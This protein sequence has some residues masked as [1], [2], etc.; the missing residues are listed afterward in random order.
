MFHIKKRNFDSGEQQSTT[1]SPV[2][3][4]SNKTSLLVV[5]IVGRRRTWTTLTA[6]TLALW[7]WLSARR[8]A[9][10]TPTVL[11]T[12]WPAARRRPRTTARIWARTTRQTTMSQNAFRQVHQ[13]QLLWLYNEENTQV[14]FSLK[15]KTI[16]QSHTSYDL[17]EGTQK[18]WWFCL[19]VLMQV[20]TTHEFQI[21]SAKKEQRVQSTPRQPWHQSE[22]TQQWWH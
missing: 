9:F 20:V 14:Y 21:I 10:A 1:E 12:S 3:N 4:R 5:L 6:T 19:E 16:C 11:A 2:A 7:T 15:T 17:F 8:T 13:N 18:Y 22:D